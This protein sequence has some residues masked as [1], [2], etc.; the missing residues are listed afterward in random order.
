MRYSLEPITTPEGEPNGFQLELWEPRDSSTDGCVNYAWK[1]RHVFQT[2]EEAIEYA[3]VA[4]VYADR[5][6]QAA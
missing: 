1:I 4:S 6:S 3:K 5:S 2:R